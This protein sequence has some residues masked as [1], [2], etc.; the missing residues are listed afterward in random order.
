M[1]LQM[2]MNYKTE[3]AMKKS[4]GK[5]LGREIALGKILIKLLNKNYNQPERLNP[6]DERENRELN[7]TKQNLKDFPLV[8]DSL[9]SENK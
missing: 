6:E 2:K 8:C 4:Y 7:F 1:N 5:N 3:K 9:N